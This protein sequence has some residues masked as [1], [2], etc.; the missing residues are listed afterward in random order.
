MSLF[1]L[2]IKTAVGYQ[3]LVH[4]GVSGVGKTWAEKR[5]SNFSLNDRD[6]Q[7]KKLEKTCG[8]MI[9]IRYELRQI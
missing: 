2:S 8:L 5:L 6:N 9:L 4:Q 3:A 1:K 7:F